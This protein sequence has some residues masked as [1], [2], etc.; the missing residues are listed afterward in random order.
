MPELQT[1]YIGENIAKEIIN[2]LLLYEI[3]NKIG[4]FT[5]DNASNNDIAMAAIAKSLKFAGNSPEC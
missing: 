5:L 1:S 4:Y 2:T 3:I